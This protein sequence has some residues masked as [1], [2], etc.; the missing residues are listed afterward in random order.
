VGTIVPQHHAH[1]VVVIVNCVRY[2]G[3]SPPE[4]GMA[5]L[6]MPDGPQHEKL[7]KELAAHECGHVIA[8]LNE[9]YNPC[10]KRDPTRIYP[11]EATQAEVDAGTVWWKSLAHDSELDAHGR[12]VATHRFDD[13]VTE[14]CQPRLHPASHESMLGAFWGCHNGDPPAETP[15]GKLCDP[16][17]K[18]FYRAMAQC[19]MRNVE[20]EFCRAC[21]E[22]LTQAITDVST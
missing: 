8:S 19:R 9:E 1:C 16:R 13:A 17:G 2:G 7:F 12:F 14:D 5:F 21:S 18:H 3:S 15:S 20:E 11:N 22:L 10:N 4:L 6:T